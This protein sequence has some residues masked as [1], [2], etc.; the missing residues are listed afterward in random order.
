MIKAR[1]IFPLALAGLSACSK[2]PDIQ[3][4]R[5]FDVEITQTAPYATSLLVAP[6]APGADMPAVKGCKHQDYAVLIIIGIAVE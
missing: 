3:Q 5:G 2:A 4:N 6:T 1:Y